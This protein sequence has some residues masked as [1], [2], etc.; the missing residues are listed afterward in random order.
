METIK[1]SI[2]S[3]KDENIIEY[4]EILVSFKTM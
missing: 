1:I 3:K 4:E 2:Y